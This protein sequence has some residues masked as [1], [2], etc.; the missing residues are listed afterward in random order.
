MVKILTV[1]NVLILILS[2]SIL[3]ISILFFKISSKTNDN[4][5]IDFNK[6]SLSLIELDL[7]SF[8]LYNNP[9]ISVMEDYKNLFSSKYSHSVFK[10]HRFNLISSLLLLL[11]P[12]MLIIFV[13][14]ILGVSLRMT[15]LVSLFF[16]L[17]SVVPIF[18]F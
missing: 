10:L 7:Q 5:N 9:S 16:F 4:L 8:L 6:E 14:L 2:L 18:L 1:K 17:F 15:L 12:L 13:F 3:L 11:L